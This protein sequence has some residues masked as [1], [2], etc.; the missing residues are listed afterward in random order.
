MLRLKSV[1]KPVFHIDV[2]DGNS[3]ELT[4]RQTN[5]QM[6]GQTFFKRWNDASKNEAEAPTC[7]K[8]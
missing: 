7:V 6:D 4:N 2:K 1:E 3:E 5:H 8:R